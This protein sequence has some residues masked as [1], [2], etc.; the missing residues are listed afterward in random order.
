VICDDIDY[1]DTTCE[2]LIF[3]QSLVFAVLH[4]PVLINVTS[5]VMCPLIVLWLDLTWFWRAGW[6]FLSIFCRTNQVVWF[7]CVFSWFTC[8]WSNRY[9]AATT[10]LRTRTWF[11]TRMESSLVPVS[12]RFSS[13]PCIRH[14]KVFM[15]E[16]K[17][18][19]AWL[20]F[21]ILVGSRR[22][23]LWTWVMYVGN[24]ISKLQIQVAT[25]VFELSAGNCHR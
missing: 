25:Y 11:T 23:W 14:L 9:P 18:M 5:R 17:K 19:S 3:R 15:L 1:D 21:L 16:G 8:E 24:S 13:F 22:I 6:S 2:I 20:T 4:F 10:G 12:K 7:N